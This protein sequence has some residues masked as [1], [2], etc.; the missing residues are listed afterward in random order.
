MKEVQ[1]H[2]YCLKENI[3]FLELRCSKGDGVWLLE[4]DPL[5]DIG[6]WGVNGFEDLFQL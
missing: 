2:D 3:Y 1:Q 4:P 5:Q 6:R